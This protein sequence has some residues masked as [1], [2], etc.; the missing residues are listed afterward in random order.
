MKIE[1]CN[2][3]YISIGVVKYYNENLKGFLRING[4][5]FDYGKEIRD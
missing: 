1:L 5:L 4:F 3:K 2:I